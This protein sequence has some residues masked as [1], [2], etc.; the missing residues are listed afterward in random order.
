MHRSLSIFYVV[1]VTGFAANSLPA[2]KP[3]QFNRDIRPILSENCYHCHGPD[4]SGRKADLRLDTESGAKEYAIVE[5][6]SQSS[7]L[8]ARIFSDDPDLLMPPADS[9]RTLTQDERELL[10]R[11]VDEGASY[12]RH[13]S[14]QKPTAVEPPDAGREWANNPI[15]RFVIAQLDAQALVPAEQADK[16]TLLRRMTFDLIGL[17]P[18]SDEIDAYLADSSPRSTERVIDRLLADPRYGERM[19]ADWLDV[20]RYSDTYG[21]QVDRDRFVW[22]WR[23][24]VVAAFNRNLGY[25]E[26]LREQLAGD[27]L[28]DPTRDQI[29]A[30]TFNRLHPQKVEGGSVPE[31]FR[32]EYIADRT[33][34]VGTAFL[35]LTMEC[36]RCH[37]HKYDPILHSEYYQL[38]AF[39]A[40]IDEAGLYS[41]FTPSVPTPTLT[42]PTDDQSSQLRNDHA[43]VDQALL[44]YRRALAKTQ[45]LPP[46]DQWMENSDASSE[47]LFAKPIETLDFESAPES[48]NQSIDGKVGKAIRLTG[49]DP[50][51]LKSGNF[52]R[53]QPFSVSLWMNS[54]DV[55]QRAVIFHR[56]RAWTDAA[57]RGYQLLIEDGRLSWS[58][59]HFWPGN[60]IR[61]QTVDPIPVDQ[62]IH[63]AVTSD[64][65]SRANGLAIS[66]NGQTAATEVI[67]DT[68]TK[69]IT[70]GGGD[71]IAIGQR[72]RDR[73]FTGGAVDSFDV[74]DCEL[75]ELEI[76]RLATADQSLAWIASPVQDWNA[77]QRRLMAD[78]LQRRHDSETLR[79]RKELGDARRKLC[80]TQDAL[81][82]IMVMRELSQPRMTHRLDRG[83]YDSPA[84]QVQ[85]G[86]PEA[87]YPFDDRF[88]SD[89]LG[90]AEWML[91][92]DNPLTARVA[93]NRLW[94]MCFGIGLVRTP[95]DFGSQGQSPTHPELLDWLAIDFVQHDWDIKRA[96]KQIMLSSTYQLSSE[97]SDPK[98]WRQDPE[99]RS[100]ARHNAY[101]LPAEMLRDQS[102]AISGSLV[103]EIGGP[104]VK[105]YEVEAS[106]KPTD[107]D[108]GAGL[109]RRSLYTY[110]KRT[111]PAPAMMTLD[112]S[113][114]DVCRVRRERTSSPLQ[115][116][117]LLNGPQY[118][119]AARGLACELIDRH[120]D[121]A[122]ALLSAAFRTLTSRAAT[123]AE[124]NVLNE[125]YAKQ[126][127]YFQNHPERADE[128]LAVGER[129]LPAGVDRPQLAATG[130]VIGALMNFDESVMKR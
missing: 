36:C 29:L 27:L 13:W 121:D 82:E 94:Q 25:D 40:N 63:V 83:A 56:S 18:T 74:F 17:P 51:D 100:L 12:Q 92:A 103:T 67:R 47:P 123:A 91:S 11:W 30:T 3:L 48:P 42:L 126:L 20:A 44:E 105:P 86:T 110:W 32:L 107:R 10:R 116:F 88:R 124:S 79:R 106:F 43:D 33:Q 35:G 87:I 129:Q 53:D 54:P 61:I 23:D 90:L 113:K 120:R 84:E 5:S 101:R 73:G 76:K 66:I 7:E 55:K 4:E 127:A 16:E 69:N 112:A 57:S 122:D 70:G 71:Q 50:V 130:V 80:Q 15:D 75:T 2:Q 108:K 1:L 72:F 26:F 64:G 46:L 98:V 62:W 21:F 9:E 59:I 68:L 34:T 28:P 102:L 39:F 89:R 22:P 85:P 97:H 31:E 93:V 24:W 128:Y 104:P 49:D 38:S 111:G 119:E 99:N 6:D 118:V 58:L 117:V 109:Y 95:E 65:S 37:T 125:L 52:R 77:D 115:A 114:R 81:Q 96:V 19:A 45:H 14:F 41:Y 60:A 8:I 78:H